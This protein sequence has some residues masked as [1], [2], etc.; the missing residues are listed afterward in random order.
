[1][2]VTY[3]LLIIISALFTSNQSF[4]QKYLE[5]ANAY[6]NRNLFEEA[7]EYYLKEL[8]A[9]SALEIKDEA[10][11]KLANCYR[12][13][14]Q[15]IEAEKWYAD[16]M[17]R[18]RQDAESVLNYAHALKS[19]AKY[20]EAKE[21]Y[22]KYKKKVPEDPMADIYIQSCD[23]A[24]E[25]L[26]EFDK[27]EVKNVRAINSAD[28]DFGPNY[29]ENG[30]VFSSSR[31]G[32]KKKFIDLTGGGDAIYMD[33]YY[34]SLNNLEKVSNDT[35]FG[36]LNSVFH[37]GP[38][39]F[40][41]D[42][43]EVYFT[44]TVKAKK[45]KGKS[46]EEEK[47]KLKATLQ[48]FYS[49][50]DSAGNWTTPR[51][52]FSFNSFEYSV[53]QPTLSPS[54]NAI[55]F[56]S[57]MPGGKGKTDIYVA[58]K[59]ANGK[60][61]EPQNLG[62]P[63]NT[64]G[65]ELTP[66]IYN[67]SILYFGSDVHPGIGKIDI[68]V[69]YKRDGKWQSPQNLKPPI[70]SIADD[71]SL[72]RDKQSNK[73]FFCSNR[74]NGL[75]DYDIYTFYENKPLEVILD[76]DEFKVLDETL[77]SGLGFR[78]VTPDDEKTVLESSNDG[79]YNFEIPENTE[80]DLS[81]RKDGFSNNSVKTKFKKDPTSGYGV[82]SLKPRMKAIKYSGYLKETKQVTL[83][84][85][86]STVTQQVDYP[87]VGGKVILFEKGK[88][89]QTVYTNEEG[90]YTFDN[91]LMPRKQYDVTAEGGESIMIS[92]KGKVTYENEPMPNVLVTA[93]A[94]GMIM[95]QAKTDELGNYSLD[96]PP[97]FLFDVEASLQGY[98][99]QKAQYN[100]EEIFTSTKVTQDFALTIDDDVLFNK[101]LNDTSYFKR[102]DG[103]VACIGRVHYNGLA[104]PNASIK[105]FSEKGELIN[106]TQTDS[107]GIYA[108]NILP[109]S[110]FFTITEKTGYVTDSAELS[111]KIYSKNQT[112]SHY[113]ELSPLDPN[114][115]PDITC[116]G[117]V[118][119]F[120]DTLP[121][122]II[123]LYKDNT[124]LNDFVTGE[125]GTF[126]IPLAYGENYKI[127]AIKN[128][129]ITS[130]QTISTQN[131]NPE[132]PYYLSLALDTIDKSNYSL[133]NTRKPNTNEIIALINNDTQ[134]TKEN[135]QEH[136]NIGIQGVV[137]DNTMNLLEKV[138]VTIVTNDF[139][140]HET[141]TSV[142]GEFSFSI[143]PE[144][145]FFVFFAKEY[146]ADTMLIINSTM[147]DKSNMLL[148]DTLKLNEAKKANI[149]IETPDT[150][151]SITDTTSANGIICRGKVHYQQ[152][153][154]IGATI[155]SIQN[156]NVETVIESAADGTYKITLKPETD[157]IIEVSKDTY[158]YAVNKV[159][160]QGKPL[161]TVINKDF[162]II[163][164]SVL[165]G[166]INNVVEDTTDYS[167][168][169]QDLYT[170][171]KITFNGEPVDGALMTVLQNNKAIYMTKSLSDGGYSVNLL[172][173]NEYELKIVKDNIE[174]QKISLSTIGINAENGYLYNIELNPDYQPNRTE[175]DTTQISRLDTL[176]TEI[177]IDTNN[178]INVEPPQDTV[179]NTTPAN[180]MVTCNIHVLADGSDVSDALIEIFVDGQ[181]IKVETA[182]PTGKSTI[183]LKTGFDYTIQ[184]SKDD[185]PQKEELLQAD[186]SE[187]IV[188]INID[189]LATE[190]VVEKEEQ[191][192]TSDYYE[193]T[194]DENL[195][196]DS[197]K[198]EGNIII[199][200]HGNVEYKGQIVEH[201]LVRLLRYK[202]VIDSFYTKE[203]GHYSFNIE[204]ESEYYIEAEKFGY[205]STK[206]KIKTKAKIKDVIKDL[207]LKPKDNIA[208]SGAVHDNANMLTNVEI[209]VYS[210]NIQMD[211]TV[212]DADGRFNLSLYIDE[213]YRIVATKK[214]YF[215]KEL[216]L[217]TAGKKSK[218]TVVVDMELFKIEVEKFV[219]IKNIYFDFNK[220]IIRPESH[221]QLD[222]L[223]NFLKQNDN[224][225]VEISSHAD[226]RGT[227]D[228]NMRLTRKRSQA[229]VDFLT[230][231][232]IS[233]NRLVPRAYGKSKLLI[234]NAKTES[235]HQQNRRS[236]FKV[237]SKS[238]AESAA[239]QFVVEDTYGEA[240]FPQGVTY[241]V[242]VG[243]SREQLPLGRFDIIEKSVEGIGIS[244]IRGEDGIYRYM[245]CCYQYVEQAL[246]VQNQ[247]L[248][249][250]FD[251]FVVA[252]NNGKRI[253]LKEA[254]E[255]QLKGK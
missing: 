108:M 58:Y 239:S 83:Y 21:I 41:V 124:L 248:Q 119:A 167:N 125:S 85:G 35:L 196:W 5:K 242:Q 176:A 206:K 240:Q 241:M 34:V 76:N 139:M 77:Y 161:G 102:I 68:F 165:Y 33:F 27:F 39:T 249:K 175:E 88:P 227:V 215:Q 137:V 138:N 213:D 236:E 105:V 116:K 238:Y 54:G 22:E 11:E 157:Y 81:I 192:V 224:L 155:K 219:Q 234:K 69:S 182:D 115:M 172:T 204:P 130:E 186:G 170:K 45:Q 217:S 233:K 26:M 17:K 221:V 183:K 42:L 87:I 132:K 97:G 127:E 75:G 6:Y 52:A 110:M 19:S 148:L 152:E 140:V 237:I 8:D 156:F 198:P 154:I 135:L 103:Y 96:L 188:E 86:D 144:N 243:E 134:I 93:N 99:T 171:G 207:K 100:A 63:I 1:M 95:N 66:Y 205:Y 173:E 122:C 104:I 121:H 71:Y 70:N 187:E 91:E 203:N 133:K 90:F 10:K 16:I 194:K 211:K 50:K 3:I 178:N 15:F 7:I 253:S 168:Q 141:T 20:D 129:Y 56:M 222:K 62:A 147:A 208:L 191:N 190:Q 48:V 179:D 180:E 218:E 251:A 163:P 181:L 225:A 200:L 252:F 65:H 112:F 247:I 61:G 250:G 185:M 109:K 212:S 158:E 150:S 209:I 160:T 47:G 84:F 131:L 55:Y 195:D 79:Y 143:L 74:F 113:I 228:Y 164:E 107:D 153:P 177:I 92:Y 136:S 67:D 151:N 24:L 64:F 36:S 98:T 255:L 43:D 94:Y 44:R 78:L 214:G 235:E 13:T 174:T 57:D 162:E 193:M 25:W 28:I 230:F 53:A 106:Q 9:P 226:E 169:P 118:V 40:S 146:Y 32:S 120:N 46:S 31:E 199:N 231:K 29:Y 4:A 82:A 254:K 14:G 73:G 123:K 210:N 23:S 216:I 126:E 184:V 30:I 189:L 128:G 101:L 245:V 202:E 60:W 197:G 246:N 229:V 145:E 117:A 2:K 244:Y 166:E 72:I 149:T 18:E 201:A 80:Y 89:V 59:Q 159:S 38:A 49:K 37:E 51:S 220:A 142:T 114:Q 111:T 232:G 12:L 223:T